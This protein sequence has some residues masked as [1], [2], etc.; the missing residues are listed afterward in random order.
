[1]GALQAALPGVQPPVGALT[2][3]PRARRPESRRLDSHAPSLPISSQPA[4]API[5]GK[6]WAL[7]QQAIAGDTE[8]QDALFANHTAR[9]Y[10]TAFAILRNKED[11]E[12]AVQEGLCN[13]YVKL[14]SFQGRSSFTTWLTRIV[15]NSALMSRR[16]KGTHPEASLDEMLSD[17]EGCLTHQIVDQRPNPENICSSTEFSAILEREV[18]KLPPDVQRAFRLREIEHFTTA[19]SVRTLGIGKNAF[20]SRVLRGRRKLTEALRR[21]LQAPDQ[22][23]RT[24]RSAGSG[25][26]RSRRTDFIPAVPQAGVRRAVTAA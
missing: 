13:A 15:V 16:K 8:S 17:R 24:V 9:L 2:F 21:S 7:I 1:M 5:L 19:E 25:R 23:A 22:M 4:P 12:D 20:K 10:R 14:Q 6:D 3:R 18:R 11:A 26:K